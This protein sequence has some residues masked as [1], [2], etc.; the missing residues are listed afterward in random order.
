LAVLMLFSVASA[1]AGFGSVFADGEEPVNETQQSET[2]EPPAEEL[3]EEDILPQ[4]EEPAPAEEETS[5]ASESEAPA[6][7]EFNMMPMFAPYD[8]TETKMD[9]NLE[10]EGDLTNGTGDPAAVYINGYDAEERYE[11]GVIGQAVRLDG[12]NYIELESPESAAL[13]Y[14]GNFSLAFWVNVKDARGGDPVIFSNKGWSSGN[15]PGFLLHIATRWKE[16]KLNVKT[17]LGG[18]YDQV[19]ARTDPGV[20]GWQH[21]AV[22]FDVDNN[23][24]YSYCN[25]VK[26]LDVDMDLTGGVPGNL[27]HT[28]IGQSYDN[29]ENATF[30]NGKDKSYDVDML[31]DDFVMKNETFS[32][33]YISELFLEGKELL[34][35]SGEWSDKSGNGDMLS[36]EFGESGI[37]DSS[38]YARVFSGNTGAENISVDETLGKYVANMGGNAANAYLTP[39]S[40]QDYAKT[41]DAK[42]DGDGDDT[43]GDG[44]TAAVTFKAELASGNASI[45]GNMTDAEGIGLDIEPNDANTANLKLYMKTPYTNGP[46]IELPGAVTYGEWYQATAVYDGYEMALYLN[47]VLR[48]TVRQW[49]DLPV[50]AAAS[51]F[52]VIGGDVDGNGEAENAFTGAIA[53]LRIYSRQLSEYEVGELA[54]RDMSKGG[55]EPPEGDTVTFGVISDTHITETNYTTQARTTEAF[56]FYSE[57]GTDAVVVVGDLSDN[58]NIGQLNAWKAAMQAGKSDDVRLIASMGNHE[59]NKWANFESATGNKANDVKIVNGYYFITVSPGAGTL[60]AETGRASQSN[61]STYSYAVNWLE[62]QLQIAEAASPDKPVFV[63]FHHPIRN[64]FYASHEWY[65]FG[66]ETVFDNH[67]RAVTFAGHIHSPN[68]H[69]K[70]IWQKEGGYTAINTVT[71]K[72]FEMETGMIYG[73]VPPN[74]GNAAQG[75]LVTADGSN[76]TVKNY[77]FI[78]HEWIEQTWSFDATPGAERPYTAASRVSQ[79]VAPEFDEDAEISVT[80]IGETVARVS[81]PQAH[82]PA[83]GHKDDIVQSY[84]YDFINKTTGLTDVSFKTFSDYYFLPTPGT[85][86]SDVS[87][88]KRGTEY[89]VRIYAYDAMGAA[90]GYQGGWEGGGSESEPL[91]AMFTTQGTA[92]EAADVFD[93]YRQGVAPAD[94][95]DVDFTGG[96][97]SDHALNRSFG[98]GSAGNIT[99]S[100]ELGKYAANFTGSTSQ[101]WITAWSASDYEKTLDGLTLESVFKVDPFTGG[102]V[103]LAGNMQSAGYGLEIVPESS[104]TFSLEFWCHVGGSYKIPKVTGLDFNRWY[105]VAGVYDKEEGMVKLYVDGALKAGFPASGDIS[106]PG[107]LSRSFVIGGDSNSNSGIEAAMR[108][109]VS[110]ARIYSEPL[111]DTQI[112][113]LANRELPSIDD[114]APIIRIDGELPEYILIDEGAVLPAIKAADNSSSVTLT[115][116]IDGVIEAMGGVEV[117]LIPEYE[118]PN[119]EALATSFGASDLQLAAGMGVSEIIFTLKAVDPSGNE[120]EVLRRIA[121]RSEEPGDPDPTDPDPTDPDPSVPAGYDGFAR[122]SVIE[123]TVAGRDLGYDL[124]VD[125]D[126]NKIS[127]IEIEFNYDGALQFKS[128]TP[129]EGFE[130]IEVNDG[131]DRKG[132]ERD[133]VLFVSMMKNDGAGVS[134]QNLTNILNLTFTAANPKAAVALEIAYIGAGGYDAEG[135]S[136]NLRIE[137]PAPSET[138]VFHGYD[139]DLNSSVDYGDVAEMQKHLGKNSESVGWNAVSH[140]DIADNDDAIDIADL[141]Q[142]LVYIRT[143]L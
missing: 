71:L 91:T 72:Y 56:E 110:A 29:S 93:V 61:T 32:Q 138:D 52:F 77:D 43:G 140:M 9:F 41:H 139:F 16:I 34:V 75:L 47:G 141:M 133:G 2:G 136:V 131:K 49:N 10:F 57:L 142:I 20:T 121:L 39:W 64:T 74:S 17:E 115:A 122:I 117:N 51:R 109:S 67:P 76:V 13:D 70:S 98:G 113:V 4:S 83:G 85:I 26:R 73:S 81:F 55:E 31:L 89:E 102:F 23:K 107:A 116:K 106:K 124:S 134:V 54:N 111:N 5:E 12:Y 42:F 96:V 24:I 1:F 46:Y 103:D 18:R 86:G 45:F 88:L 79:A 101:A 80:Q 97:I 59:E 25:G 87:G 128:A 44:M 33:S 14:S 92:P 129:S 105:H 130:L 7:E 78:S 19:V 108:G 100:D 135:K 84:K 125:A 62:Q 119:A 69:P 65:G 22:V 48:G 68:N 127:I 21:V 6:E 99:F 118:I 137:A 37:A 30:Y 112:E 126:D 15:N 38:A 53:S 143:V 35:G 58:G 132:N 50:P 63:F 82:I 11:D 95:L 40:E 123:K 27:L 66:F 114:T 120:T 94:M 90:Q 3:I 28:L 60:D 8:A 104:N 36:A